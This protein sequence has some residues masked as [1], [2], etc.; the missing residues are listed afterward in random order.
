M[1]GTIGRDI[2]WRKLNEKAW[3]NEFSF[4]P[5]FSSSRRRDTR[6]R[7]KIAREPVTLTWNQLSITRKHLEQKTSTR[8]NGPTHNASSVRDFATNFFL[9]FPRLCF[10]SSPVFFFLFFFIFFANGHL[11]SNRRTYRFQRTAARS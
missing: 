6:N 5:L 11:S 1:H 7:E 3:G 4:D 10:I 9:L 2:W 8:K